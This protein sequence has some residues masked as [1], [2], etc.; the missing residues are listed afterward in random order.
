M[1]SGGTRDSHGDTSGDGPQYRIKSKSEGFEGRAL[2][3]DL[4]SNKRIAR[5]LFIDA[6]LTQVTGT[7]P[8]A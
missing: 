6:A 4:S 2:E 8:G 3:R 7:N 1:E 5:S